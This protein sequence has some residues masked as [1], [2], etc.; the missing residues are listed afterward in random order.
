MPK[1]KVFNG[2]FVHEYLQQNPRLW[3]ALA[4]IL[5]DGKSQQKKSYFEQKTE[6]NSSTLFVLHEVTG[7]P[8]EYFF[9]GEGESQPNLNS[10][11]QHIDIHHNSIN[12]LNANT[13]PE[14][15][16][17]YIDMA[18]QLNTEKEKRIATLEETIRELKD[19]RDE[20]LK[21]FPVV[22]TS[23]ESPKP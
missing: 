5:W 1:S 11:D 2:K 15:L 7:L 23:S 17:A 20:L 12:T 9:I 3:R 13:N 8:W 22:N 14:V 6:V 4:D 10:I 16:L 18:K 19:S 21:R